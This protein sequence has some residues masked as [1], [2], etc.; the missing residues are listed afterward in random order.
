M[1]KNYLKK[2]R[3]S[4][5]MSKAELARKANISPITISR[6]ENGMPCR[7]ETKR[8]IILALGLKISDKNKVFGKAMKLSIKD[9]G[10]RSNVDRHLEQRSDKERRS[11][12]DR[13]QKPRTS[14]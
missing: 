13:R 11:K 2:I 12:L 10:G 3:Q 9:K 1:S 14:E 5:M 6:I 8:K 4:L 7:L